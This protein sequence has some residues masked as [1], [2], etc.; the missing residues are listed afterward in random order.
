[1]TN[2]KSKSKSKET[3]SLLAKADRIGKGII[4]RSKKAKVSGSTSVFIRT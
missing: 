4:S 2:K 1:M 3:K